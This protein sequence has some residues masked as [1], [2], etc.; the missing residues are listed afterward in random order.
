[1]LLC[2]LEVTDLLALF[3]QIKQVEGALR[4]RASLFIGGFKGDLIA[5]SPSFY[6]TSTKEDK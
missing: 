4:V 3:G 5:L 6:G 2:K 1:M